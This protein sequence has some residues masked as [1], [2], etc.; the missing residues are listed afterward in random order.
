MTC[1]TA[2]N[3][4]EG[5]DFKGRANRPNHVLGLGKEPYT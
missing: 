1:K 2:A 5:I 3:L 4:I